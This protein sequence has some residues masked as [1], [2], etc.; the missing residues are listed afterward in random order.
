MQ[1]T[2]EK[3]Q[4]RLK[5]LDTLIDVLVKFREA[6]PLFYEE[7]NAVLERQEDRKQKEISK[8]VDKQEN[9]GLI[10]KHGGNNISL[11]TPHKHKGKKLKCTLA[12][13]KEI[14]TKR[15]FKTYKQ[16]E[17]RITKKGKDGN[18]RKLR[19]QKRNWEE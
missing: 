7:Y 5:K 6:L 14:S 17:E 13:N 8:Y 11:P 12:T 19:E 16:E 15:K 18:K 1:G 2:K 4:D 9:K 3:Q 10:Y